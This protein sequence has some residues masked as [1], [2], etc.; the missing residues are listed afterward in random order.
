MTKRHERRVLQTR[1]PMQMLPTI[2]NLKP[3]TSEKRFVSI[4]FLV[5]Q[6]IQIENVHGSTSSMLVVVVLVES[7]KTKSQSCSVFDVTMVV[8]IEM[9]KAIPSM[10]LNQLS[11]ENH[12]FH[13]TITSSTST[14]TNTTSTMQNLL[15]SIELLI[16]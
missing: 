14:S 10:N 4:L 12:F 6:N 16:C 9:K 11:R 2:I 13:A 3:T 8:G 1:V 15:L 7:L 5:K